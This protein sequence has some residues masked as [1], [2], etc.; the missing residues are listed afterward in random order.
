MNRKIK[1]RDFLT[2]TS[3]AGVCCCMLM[4]NNQYISGET[5]PDPKKLNYCGYQCPP[6]CQFLKG[7]LENNIEIKK[8]AYKLWKIKE[9]FDIEFDPETIFCYGCKNDKKPAG[10]IL[11]N[12]TVRE[13]AIAKNY[14]CCIECNE[15]KNCDKELWAKFP[16]FR[17]KVIQMQEKF[18][19]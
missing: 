8:E 15:L 9:R 6:E 3:K 11:T 17:R 18:K 13:C 10:I 5:M 7:S 12:C 4:L 14:D 1:R 2:K 19:V 16:E